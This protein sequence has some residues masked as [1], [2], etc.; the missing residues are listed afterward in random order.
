MSYINNM[1]KAYCLT[2]DKGYKF[3]K[4]VDKGLCRACLNVSRHNKDG[5]P[6]GFNANH[7]EPEVLEY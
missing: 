6:I 2:C 7:I 1:R 4:H 3:N 5:V